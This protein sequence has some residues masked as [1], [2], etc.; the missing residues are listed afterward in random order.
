MALEEGR[1]KPP[2]RGAQWKRKRGWGC[3]FWEYQA[4][5]WWLQW[6]LLLQPTRER[7]WNLNRREEGLGLSPEEL[8]STKTIRGGRAC[9]GD[10]G[11][12]AREAEWQEVWSLKSQEKRGFQVGG[13]VSRVECNREDKLTEQCPLDRVPW[14]SLLC[15]GNLV[16][17]WGN[18]KR[19]KQQGSWGK[20]Q[21]IV[22]Q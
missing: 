21:Q 1:V 11:G 7:G 20:R 12:E 22:E 14:E 5:T 4:H 2:E 10:E 3:G 16:E 17:R 18:P 8:Q 19:V 15:R 6:W 9:E 13:V